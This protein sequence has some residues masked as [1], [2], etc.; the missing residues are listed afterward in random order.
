MASEIDKVIR[1]GGRVGV[2]MSSEMRDKSDFLVWCVLMHRVILVTISYLTGD[3]H[4]SSHII[5]LFLLFNH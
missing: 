4:L 3:P 5:Y 1:N 2:Q